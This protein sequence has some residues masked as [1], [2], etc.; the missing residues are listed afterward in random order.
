MNKSEAIEAMKRGQKVTHEN[1]CSSEWMTIQG[2]SI[3]FEDGV[4]SSFSE[5]WHFRKDACW[6]DGYSIW[7]GGAE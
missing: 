7:Q 6:E 5:F 1:F 4:L 3:L 2:G